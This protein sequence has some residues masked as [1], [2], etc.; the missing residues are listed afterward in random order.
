MWICPRCSEQH[1]DKFAECW[2]CAAN[3]TQTG[4]YSEGWPQ[5]RSPLR[6][7]STVAPVEPV[8]SSQPE[9]TLRP[10]GYVLVRAC[11]GFV[12]GFFATMMF[13][14]VATSA[15][16]AIQGADSAALTTV[17]MSAIGGVVLALIVGVFFWVVFPYE[18]I[19]KTP[20]DNDA[21]S[22]QDTERQVEPRL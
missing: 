21:N 15:R 3:E 22:C 9:R 13:L 20:V 1:D 7:D 16:I 2:K 4:G 10:F 6:P 8:V 12:V 5:Y 19:K 18:P 17:V 14:N 11:I